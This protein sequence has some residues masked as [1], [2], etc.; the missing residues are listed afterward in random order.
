M[1]KTDCEVVKTRG[2]S[3]FGKRCPPFWLTRDMY[4]LLRNKPTRARTPEHLPFNTNYIHLNGT[5]PEIAPP[6]EG[7]GGGQFLPYR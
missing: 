5:S 7:G 6:P 1:V 4:A 3:R 2:N